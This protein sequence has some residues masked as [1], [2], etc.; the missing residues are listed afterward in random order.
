LELGG[1]HRRTGTDAE[2]E[3][4]AR[5]RVERER[6]AGDD[7]RMAQVVVEDEG[8]H[9]QRR[10]GLHRH[11]EGR[12]RGDAAVDEVIRHGQDREAEALG[13]SGQLNPGVTV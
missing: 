11:A 7:G 2:F 13:P 9:A 12:E 8:S 4:A 1:A 5:Q 6:L 10:G 3:P